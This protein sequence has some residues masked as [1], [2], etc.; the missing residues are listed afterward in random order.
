M[1]SRSGDVLE[2]DR[3]GELPTTDISGANVG[4]DPPAVGCRSVVAPGDR[5][6]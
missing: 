5:W 4:S 1:S 2:R 6:S 3:V